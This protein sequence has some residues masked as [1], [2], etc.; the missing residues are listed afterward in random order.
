M[1]ENDINDC[2]ALVI[3]FYKNGGKKQS[4]IVCSE[5]TGI[6]LN[7]IREYIYDS[8]EVSTLEYIA[9]SLGYVI[10]VI[11]SEYE[12]VFIDKNIER[13]I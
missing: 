1:K 9:T 7:K 4:L 8:D 3:W 10:K 12:Y 13:F 11:N 6:P 2:I 5:E